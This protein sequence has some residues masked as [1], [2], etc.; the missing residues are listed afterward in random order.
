MK[1]LFLLLIAALAAAGIH[2]ESLTA[3]KAFTEAPASVFPLLDAPT[4]LDMVDYSA[5]GMTTA[6]KNNLGGNSVIT[7][8]TP[9][10]LTI[11]MSDASTHTLFIL[12]ASPEP[13]IGLIRTVAT[14]GNDSSLSLYTAQW[15][16]SKTFAAPGL[17]DWVT[18]K[19]HM[20]DVELM[21]PFML[22]GYDYDPQ[23]QQLTLTN[24]LQSF[25][26]EDV[27]AMVAPYMA[28]KL[29][30]SWDGRRFVPVK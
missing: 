13:M 1:K 18:D 12:P 29:V 17:K 8:M 4:R 7:E 21:V 15:Q 10:K 6:S 28:S 24:N 26:S 16:P 5:A 14:P 25:L 23:T 22:V 2:A 9:D 11:K 27:Y 30:Y 3:A 20:A 19:A